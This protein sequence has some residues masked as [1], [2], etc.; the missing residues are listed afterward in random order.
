MA[1][2]L[3]ESGK[4]DEGDAVVI[5]SSNNG[6]TFKFKVTKAESTPIAV[7]LVQKVLQFP[8]EDDT[9]TEI[10]IDTFANTKTSTQE[11]Q[12]SGS[13]LIESTLKNYFGHTSFLPLQ[14]ETIVS[15]M[16]GESVLTVAGTGGGKS[17]MYLLPAVLSSKVTMVVSPLKSLID[18]TLIRCLNLNISACKLTGDIPLHIRTERVENACNY[19]V[20]F[21]T[22]ECL[23][24]GEPLR[25]K[26]DELVRLNKL[27]RI[28]LTRRTPYR[29][30]E[31]LSDLN[32][33]QCVKACPQ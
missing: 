23:E 1:F 7:E 20:I 17:L 28:L 16:A 22:P 11:M 21:V 14:R 3:L 25:E 29:H 33:K 15:T 12:I 4:L 30:A 5:V 31:V 26:I 6:N 18:D 27:E 32:L 10:G 9:E 19:R 8:D 13:D 24:D 2:V